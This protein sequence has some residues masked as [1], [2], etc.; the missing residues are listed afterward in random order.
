MIRRNDR[1]EDMALGRSFAFAA[2]LALASGA[3]AQ[4]YPTKPIRFIA[5]FAAGGALDTLTRTIAA[6]M[7]D[8]WSQPVVVENRTGAGGNIGADLVAKAS[9]DGYTLVMGTIATHAIN[10][11][12]YSTMP[13]D[14]VKDFA[15]VTI[16]ASINNSLSVHPSVPAKNVAELIAYAKANPGKLTFGSAGNGTS[17]HLAG[18]LFK[19]MAGVDM[20][21]VPYK[22]G[23]PAVQ[24]LLSGEV[25][26]TA[27]S[28]NTALP[29]IQSGKARPLG[30]ASSKRSPALPD[31]PTFNESGIPFEV[32]SWLAILGPAGIPADVVKKLNAEFAAAL[33]SPDVQERLAKL[34]LVVVASAPAEVNTMLAR[35]EP[36]WGKAVKDSGAVVE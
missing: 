34:G 32:D 17:Q 11:S 16:A 30:V 6:R 4:T 28:V 14:A 7:Q 24:A 23:A 10:V 15:P 13:Y 18:E 35:E 8:K 31:V 25:Q 2:A 12:L 20:V 19:T 27:V 5:P 3:A 29:H 36:K 9:P 26:L 22:G 21:H 33:R 1:E